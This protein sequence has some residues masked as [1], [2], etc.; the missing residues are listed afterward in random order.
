MANLELREKII[1]KIMKDKKLSHQDAE[2]EFSKVTK[3]VPEKDWDKVA[4]GVRL[5]SGS[6]S[7]SLDSA[8]SL[9]TDVEIA[10]HFAVQA[11]HNMWEYYLQ[12][13]Q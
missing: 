12:G 11:H 6:P 10:K 5:Q 2:K 4:G 13:N 7:A 9:H 8:S 3:D 1:Q